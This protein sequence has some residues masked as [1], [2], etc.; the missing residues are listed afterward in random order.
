MKLYNTLSRKKEDLRPLKEEVGLYTCGPTVY[1]Y[2]HI[3][4]L[5][6]YIFEDV[7][8]R[9]LYYNNYKVKHVMNITDVGHLTSD[10]DTGEDKIEASAK[11]KKKSAFEIA[12]YYTQAF[13]ENIEDLNIVSPDIYVKATETIKEQLDLIKLLEKKGFTYQIEDGIYFDTSKL[14]EYGELAK[15]KE[16]KLKPGARV[17]VKGKKNITDFA[18]WKFSK[19]DDKRQ[20]EWESPWGTGFPGWH[21]ECVVMAHKYLGVPFDIHCG[22]VDHIS[23]HH[24][25]E[26]AQSKAG[27][28]DNLATLW[29]HGEFLNLKDRKMSKSKG[30]FITLYDLKEENIPPLAYRYLV[31]GAHYRSILNFSKEA[32]ENAKNGLKNLQNRVAELES[33][34]GAVSPSYKEEFLSAV[35]DDLDTPKALEVTWRMIKDNNLDNKTKKATVE[36]F[37]KLLGLKLTKMPGKGIP[38]EI[39]KLLKEREE[40]R[41]NKDFK[42]AD[43]LREK[44][45][46]KGYSVED[47][48]DG[49]KIK[50]I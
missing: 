6:T 16:V 31:L 41:K 19:P 5:R 21:T 1:D 8:K 39:T 23:V 42:K 17:E 32:I 33:E 10:E 12:E 44:I 43:E 2:A 7:L 25:N 40:A 50:K 4:N 37:D 18:L 45:K 29:M 3:G 15:L 24:T 27:F 13:K 9:A 20:M 26:I 34:K 47:T 38:E 14:N 46:K 28:E 36:D 49:Y 35:S 48:K 22:G 11:K 30:G